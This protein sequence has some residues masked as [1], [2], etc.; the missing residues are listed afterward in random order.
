MG[1]KVVPGGVLFRLWAPK[2]A[3]VDVVL[4]KGEI[5]QCLEPEADGWWSGMVTT[6]SDGMTYQ[7]QLDGKQLCPDPCSRFQPNGPDGPSQIVDPS[8]YQWQDEGWQGI[9]MH[10]QVIYELHIGTF[11]HEGTFE[12]AITKIDVQKSKGSII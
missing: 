5:I 1:A 11:T 12:A 9:H 8:T 3:R 7:Y 4:N 10:G 6:A 2:A